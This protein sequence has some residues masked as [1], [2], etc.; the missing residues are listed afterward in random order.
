MKAKKPAD[1]PEAFTEPAGGPHAPV[2]LE[3]GVDL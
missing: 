2:G 1:N 3:P